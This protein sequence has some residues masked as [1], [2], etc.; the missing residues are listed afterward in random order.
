MAIVVDY[1]VSCHRWLVDAD[2]GSC[3]WLAHGMTIMQQL[4][5]GGE[6]QRN[7]LG[8]SADFGYLCDDKMTTPKPTN[9]ENEKAI[10]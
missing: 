6:K 7:P 10:A 9:Y 1:R 3:G 5:L 2:R 4:L 8:G